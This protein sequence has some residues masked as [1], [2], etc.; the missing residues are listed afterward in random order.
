MKTLNFGHREMI[1]M[2]KLKQYFDYSLE[3]AAKTVA[4]SML[5]TITASSVLSIVDLDFG[6]VLGVAGLAGLMSLLTSVLTFEGKT[7]AAE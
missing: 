2:D 4:Q 3:R 5:A 6:T 1:T 7:K